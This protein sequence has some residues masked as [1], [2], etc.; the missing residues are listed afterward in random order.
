MTIKERHNL[1]LPRVALTGR[2]RIDALGLHPKKGLVF[3]GVMP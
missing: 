2:D 3:E 1:K